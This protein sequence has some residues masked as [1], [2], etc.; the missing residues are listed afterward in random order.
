MS[1]L[2]DGAL[3][4]LDLAVAHGAGVAILLAAAAPRYSLALAAACIASALLGALTASL[5]PATVPAGFAAPALF[6]AG[7]LGGLA[8]ASE[9]RWTAWASASLGAFGIGLAAGGAGLTFGV[10]AAVVAGCALSVIAAAGALAGLA[11]RRARRGTIAI[12]LASGWAAA[13]LALVGALDVARDFG[14]GPAVAHPSRAA[15]GADAAEV[16]ALLTRLY[17]A[18][19]MTGEAE[20]YDAIAEAATG[21]LVET[22]Y[23]ERRAALEGDGETPD[24]QLRFLGLRLDAYAPGPSTQDR[25][26]ATVAWVAGARIGHFGHAHERAQRYAADVDLALTEAGWRFTGFALRDAETV[27]PEEGDFAAAIAGAAR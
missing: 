26:T 15:R 10:A 9:G 7:A 12:R 16:E 8:L 25:R 22:L 3:G 23:L 27:P 1:G 14:V 17:E 18:Y 11:V 4:A 13:A 20:T 24:E 5:F 6:G 2:S 21:P 19:A